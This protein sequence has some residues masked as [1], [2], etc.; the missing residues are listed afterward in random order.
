MLYRNA[1]A[2]NTARA[3]VEH[4]RDS[5]LGRGCVVV[6]VENVVVGVAV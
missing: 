1:A 4:G 5:V 3:C 2:Y 6:R